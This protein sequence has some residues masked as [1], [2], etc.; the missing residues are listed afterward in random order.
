VQFFDIPLNGNNASQDYY[1]DGRTASALI[2]DEGD[3]R[4][5]NTPAVDEALARTFTLGSGG[6][7]KGFLGSVGQWAILWENRFLV[8]NILTTTRPSAAYNFSTFHT[9]KWT[10]TQSGAN[11]AWYWTTSANYGGLKS[12]SYV[13]VPFFAF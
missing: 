2:Q 7:L 8:D 11:S 4:N 12:G 1:Y 3:R 9:N 5:I 10:S 6:T 13:V